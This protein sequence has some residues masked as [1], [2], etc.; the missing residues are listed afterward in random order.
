MQY[1]QSH[2]KEQVFIL[3]GINRSMTPRVR[4]INIRL[5]LLPYTTSFKVI[6][7]LF[8]LKYIIFI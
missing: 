7:H 6:V 4:S 3:C 2:T 8:G 5:V 1:D